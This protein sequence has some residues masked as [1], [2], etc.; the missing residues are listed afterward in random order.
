MKLLILGF[1]AMSY[2]V[3]EAFP[4][5]WTEISRLRAEGA[6][7]KLEAEIP[8]TGP[9]W[10]TIY[11]GVSFRKHGVTNT[12]GQ[13]GGGRSKTILTSPDIPFWRHLAGEGITVG[14]INLPITY[15]PEPVTGFMVSGW[16]APRLHT[17]PHALAEEIPSDYIVDYISTVPHTSTPMEVDWLAR[18]DEETL[19]LNVEIDSRRAHVAASLAGKYKPDLLFIQ[20][21]L[22]DR[23][24]HYVQ[25]ARAQ[26]RD[27]IS[28]LILRGYSTVSALIVFM[29]QELKPDALMVISDHGWK[30]RPTDKY[31]HSKAGVFLGVGDGFMKGK[32]VRGLR[33]MDIAP[34]IFAVLDLPLPGGVDGRAPPDILKQPGYTDEE[35]KCLKAHLRAMG[36]LT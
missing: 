21:P 9:S 11:T 2:E 3:L 27:H 10:M 26:G 28:S 13:D 8:A 17:Y 34:I 31:Y 15:P 6:Y 35:K 16:P 24:G 29:R 1:D 18:D 12:W 5:M 36:Y 25:M 33:T 7:G 19:A 22:L 32:E 4:D 23:V 30:W 20:F 14:L